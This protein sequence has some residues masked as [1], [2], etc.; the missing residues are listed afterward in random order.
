M[1]RRISELITA[2]AGGGTWEAYLLL[3]YNVKGLIGRQM[4]PSSADGAKAG[5]GRGEDMR[6]RKD[7]GA[8]DHVQDHGEKDSVE[9]KSGIVINMWTDF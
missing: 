6:K 2:H 3:N 9:T 1:P 8:L 4:L 7:T 5:K